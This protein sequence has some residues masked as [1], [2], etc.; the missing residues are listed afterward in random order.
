MIEITSNLMVHVEMIIKYKV[1]V[2]CFANRND[3]ISVAIRN[4]LRIFL[5]LSFDNCCAL[6]T[7]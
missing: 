6:H 7:E 4:K 2:M 1:K 5:V 3:R